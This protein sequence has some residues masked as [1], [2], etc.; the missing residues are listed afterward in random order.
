MARPAGRG[1]RRAGRPGVRWSFSRIGLLSAVI[2]LTACGGDGGSDQ[3]PVN[4]LYGPDRLAVQAPAS[5]QVRFETSKGDVLIQVNRAWAPLGA[6]RFYTLV[7]N[8]FYD[9]IRIYRVIDGFMAQ[10]GLNGDG[11]VNSAWRNETLRDDPVQMPNERGRVTFAKGGPNSRTTEIF[12]ST[13]DNL[14]LDEDRFA[15]FGEVL[16]GMDVVD[17]WNGEYGDGPPRGQGPYAIQAAS[18]GNVYLDSAFP[19]LDRILSA[20]VVE[21]GG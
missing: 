5:F 15:P 21:E 19:A 6:D 20:V 1:S 9:D 10:F 16:E 4:P 14:Y 12:I 11:L 18:Q 2:A 17:S 13:R 3:P 8:G 7:T